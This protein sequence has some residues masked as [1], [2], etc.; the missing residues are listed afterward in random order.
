METLKA[1]L[2]RRSIRKY[3][4]Q[5]IPEEVVNDLLKA[6]MSAPSAYNEQP[7]QF[8]VINK[9]SLLDEIPKIHKHSSMITEAPMAILVCADKERFKKNNYWVQDCAA[10]TQNLLLAAF[11]KGLG[12]VWLG[13]YPREERIHGLRQLLGLQENII[14][15]SLVS[16]GYPA[17]EK[18]SSNRYDE[19]RVH[20]NGW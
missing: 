13:V 17:E 7:W 6:A 15:F 16:M 14:P 11:D 2:L 9:R 19:S 4:S 10:A 20:Y 3:T 8:I 18:P 5:P 12:A 1:I